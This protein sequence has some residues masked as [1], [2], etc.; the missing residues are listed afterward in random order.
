MA[1]GKMRN[2]ALRPR[3]KGATPGCQGAAFSYFKRA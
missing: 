3:L 1:M 2:P